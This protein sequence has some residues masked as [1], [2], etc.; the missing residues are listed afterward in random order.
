MQNYKNLLEPHKDSQFLIS[1][2]KGKGVHTKFV[3]QS[4]L[5]GL[6]ATE[7]QLDINPVI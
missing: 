6:S 2:F 5:H 7:L 1:S 4:I 3:S